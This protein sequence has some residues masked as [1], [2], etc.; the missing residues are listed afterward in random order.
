[1]VAIIAGLL[2]L[3]VGLALLATWQARDVGLDSAVWLYLVA[4]PDGRTQVWQRD[5]EAARTE[6]IAHLPGVVIECTALPAAVQAVYAVARADG[7]HDLWR[8]DVA[9]RRA[10]RW[11]DCAPDDC[12]APSPG[13]DGQSI[14]FTRVVAGRPTLWHLSLDAPAPV[15]L[16]PE[17]APGHYAVWSPDGARVAYVDPAGQ[18]CVAAPGVAE[19]LCVPALMDSPPVWSPDGEAVLVTDLRLEIGAASHILRLDVTRGVFQNLSD[20]FGVE[21]DAPAWSPDGAWIAFRRRSAGTGMGKQ[22]WLIRADGS[23]AR[24]LTKD[25]TS[26]YGVPVWLDD[27]ETLLIARYAGGSS[28]IWVIPTSGEKA[29]LVVPDGYA[30]HRLDE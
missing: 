7:G 26:H 29:T 24:P 11:L 27:G 20:V 28:E 16:F 6:L 4:A 15:S 18:V 2:A 3:L 17:D 8:V 21:D 12:R 22:I 10:R 13:P 30:P 14:V 19:T 1:M 9:R 5:A 23:D 25:T